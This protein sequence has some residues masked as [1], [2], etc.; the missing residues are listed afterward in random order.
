MPLCKVHQVRMQPTVFAAMSMLI[1][2]KKDKEQNINVG[3]CYEETLQEIHYP[4]LYDRRPS[5]GTAD[6]KGSR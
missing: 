6:P 5:F 3:F 1:T 4:Q 2:H